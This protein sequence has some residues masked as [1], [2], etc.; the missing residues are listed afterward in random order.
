MNIVRERCSKRESVVSTFSLCFTFQR[1]RE[2]IKI[3]HMRRTQLSVES[4]HILI[5]IFKRDFTCSE[6]NRFER[7]IE[8]RNYADSRKRNETVGNGNSR[9]EEGVAPLSSFGRGGS[10]RW[11]KAPRPGD[12]RIR[13]CQRGDQA[14]PSRSPLGT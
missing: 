6:S 14:A 2:I 1:E 8:R 5:G 10:P 11:K 3:S 4:Y 9:R 13:S 12:V 7:E